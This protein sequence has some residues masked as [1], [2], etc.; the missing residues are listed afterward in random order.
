MGLDQPCHIGAAPLGPVVR[1]AEN[2]VRCASQRGYQQKN[3]EPHS[4]DDDSLH[5]QHDDSPI[6]VGLIRGF[7][8]VISHEKE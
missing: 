7:R 4:R 3:K 2:H 6:G 5:F 8:V 1:R